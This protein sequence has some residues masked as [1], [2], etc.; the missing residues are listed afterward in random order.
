M[1]YKPGSVIKTYHLSR[2]KITLK[3]KQLTLMT[4]QRLLLVLQ[5]CHLYLVLL[6]VGFSMRY[7]L[8]NNR[9]ALTTPFH[10]CLD[11]AVYF[12]W[13]YPQGFPRQSLTGTVSLQS[14]DFPLQKIKA[15]SHL[16]SSFFLQKFT[17]FT[18]L[19]KAKFYQVFCDYETLFINFSIN[20]F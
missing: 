12:L 3:L 11:E 14:Q 7:L 15:I 19:I 8:P 18:I 6:Q 20:F 17:D 5:Q 13:H 1:N 10:P 9:C 16:S 2:L 4:S